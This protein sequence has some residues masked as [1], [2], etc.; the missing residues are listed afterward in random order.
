MGMFR[1]YSTAIS[2][3]SSSVESFTSTPSSVYL[4]DESSISDYNAPRAGRLLDGFS[5]AAGSRLEAVI[6]KLSGSAEQGRC[7]VEEPESISTFPVSDF[8]KTRTTTS[9]RSSSTETQASRTNVKPTPQE[10]LTILRGLPKEHPI[11]SIVD[12]SVLE[13]SNSDAIEKLHELHLAL[14]DTFGS[15]NK[16]NTPHSRLCKIPEAFDSVR[17]VWNRPTNLT[18]PTWASFRDRSKEMTSRTR[19]PDQTPKENPLSTLVDVKKKGISF[20]LVLSKEGTGPSSGK[21]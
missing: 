12:R 20:G 1:N 5:R 4:S 9:S 10:V 11:F 3:Q 14:V 18:L 7:L 17:K 21:K 8:S 2:S 16:T 19:E 6:D 13:G 15:P